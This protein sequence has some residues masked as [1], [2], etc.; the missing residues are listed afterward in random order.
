[1][2]K[3]ILLTGGAGYVG[4]HTCVALVASGY[5]VVLL[6]NFSNSHSD[7]PARLQSLTGAR[8]STIEGDVK[9]ESI[10]RRVFAEHEIDAVIHLAARKSVHESARNPLLY[11]DENVSG[12]LSLVKSMQAAGVFTLVF[13]SS[14]A[15]YGR[16]RA[17]PITENAEIGFS[18]PY[19]YTKV[20][21]EQ[22]LAQVSAADPRWVFGVLRYFN[23]AGAHPS[24]LIGEESLEPHANLIPTIAEVALGRLPEIQIFGNDCDTPDG[25]GVRD[26]IHVD[27]VAQGHVLSLRSLLTTR[28]GHVVNLGTG[29]GYSVL[30][31]IKAYS[32]ACGRDLPYVFVP[33]RDID[34]DIS[35]ADPRKAQTLLGFKATRSLEQMCATSWAWV[36]RKSAR[37]LV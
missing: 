6:D 12:L 3:T 1:M 28:S 10:L 32:D 23:P 2:K 26:Y 20:V 15:V 8:I 35:Y 27:D 30:E 17:V 22:I 37:T 16:P 34:V 7:V 14:A 25:T 21:G 13:S 18:S 31:V 24:G 36:S 5:R 4:S 33:R 9:D 29:R 19:G 11:F